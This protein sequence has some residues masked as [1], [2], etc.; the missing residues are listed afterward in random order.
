MGSR[1]YLSNRRCQLCWNSPT[2]SKSKYEAFQSVSYCSAC[3]TWVIISQ[4]CETILKV[5]TPRR[6]SI[7]NKTSPYSR[8]QINIKPFSSKLDYRLL[9]HPQFLIALLLEVTCVILLIRRCNILGSC[10]IELLGVERKCAL[11]YERRGQDD[12][13]THRKLDTAVLV[14]NMPPGERLERTLQRV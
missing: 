2:T 10:S 1:L 3:Y 6:E 5:W 7:P 9:R 8:S 12:T 13:W 4:S 14:S 11:R